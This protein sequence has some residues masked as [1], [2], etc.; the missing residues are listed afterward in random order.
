[1]S[2]YSPPFQVDDW[3]EFNEF[4]A[5][6]AKEITVDL[7][8]YHNVY[9]EFKGPRQVQYYMDTDKLAV[10]NNNRTD[11]IGLRWHSDWFQR[12]ILF[13]EEYV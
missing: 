12:V 10:Y 5:S 4:G 9:E 1:M 11:W 2:I 8:G 3:V 6:R 13:E 7:E